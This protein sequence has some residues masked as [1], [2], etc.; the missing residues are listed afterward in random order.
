MRPSPVSLV[1]SIKTSC[2]CTSVDLMRFAPAPLLLP[3]LRRYVVSLAYHVIA[4]W[5]LRI[6]IEERREHVGVIASQLTSI[7]GSL[8]TSFHFL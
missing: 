1:P 5:F 2:A 7:H 3:A 6:G 4:V 8:C